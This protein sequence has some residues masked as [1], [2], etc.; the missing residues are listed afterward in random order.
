MS[1][2]TR[3]ALWDNARFALIV[4]VVIGH[5]ISTVRTD[6]QLGFGLYAYIYLFHMPAMIALS[7]LF[8]KPEVTRENSSGL[9]R[10]ACFLLL[11]SSP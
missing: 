9:A 5:L 6:T 1:V 11:P 10:N 7:G 3:V 8:A 2:K 4:L